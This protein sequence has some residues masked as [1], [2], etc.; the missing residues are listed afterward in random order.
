MNAHGN[1]VSRYQFPINAQLGYERGLRFAVCRATVGDYYTDPTLRDN[2]QRYKDA[3]FLVTAYL[4]TA[5]REPACTRRITAKAHLDLF[6]NAVSGLQPDFPWVVDAELQR[7]EINS[8]ITNLN[9]DVVTGLYN[10][11]SKFPI[12]YTR[13]TWWDYYVNPD[14]LWG[15]CDLWAARYAAYLTS[16]WSDGLYKFRDWDT[17]KFWQYT[18]HGDGRYFGASSLDLDLDW[19]NGDEA[20]LCVYAGQEPPMSLE[21]K[22]NILWREAERNGWDLTP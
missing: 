19:F 12:I 9:K 1:D 3:G 17:W 6:F 10:A 7:T 16:P 2:W 5:P 14:T 15:Q 11:Q 4:V 8:Y 22:V 21:T 18:S 20:A 13:Q